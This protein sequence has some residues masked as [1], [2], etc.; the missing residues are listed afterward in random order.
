MDWKIKIT[1]S[2][3]LS[4]IDPVERKTNKRIGLLLFDYIC[5]SIIS[6]KM[7][8]MPVNRE[9]GGGEEEDDE[10]EGKAIPIELHRSS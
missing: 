1:T 6:Y 4:V 8:D 9:R 7:S 2:R 3:T 10:R 5:I